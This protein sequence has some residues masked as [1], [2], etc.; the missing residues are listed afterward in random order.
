MVA[1]GR[2]DLPGFRW[3]LCRP[4]RSFEYSFRSWL[5]HGGMT[6]QTSDADLPAIN[7]RNYSKMLRHRPTARQAC[8]AVAGGCP[9]GKFDRPFIIVARQKG[10]IERS[11]PR[12]VERLKWRLVAMRAS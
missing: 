3:L 6:V 4:H 7:L 9:R 5:Y 2:Q 10:R 1:Y 11:R 12:G 8:A